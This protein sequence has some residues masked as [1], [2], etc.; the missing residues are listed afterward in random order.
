MTNDDMDLV[1]EYI[2]LHSEQ[3]FATLVHRHVNLV[4]SAAIRQVRDPLL[5]EEVTQ[6][7]FIILARK[8]GTLG[9]DTILPS[10]LYRTARFAAADALKLQHRRARR[11]QE[12]WMQPISNESESEVWEQIAPSLDAAIAGLNEQDR[13]AIVLRYFQ[14]KNLQEIGAA[15]GASED[16]AK[17]RV[18]RA[19]EKLRRFLAKRGITSRAAVI[20]AAISANSVQA[21][22]VSLAGSVTA[23]AFAKGATASGSTLSLMKGALKFMAWTKAKTITVAAVVAIFAVGTTTF[24]VR[25]PDP[26]RARVEQILEQKMMPGGNQW[27]AGMD[28]LWA[29]GT[30][31][32]PHLAAEAVRPDSFLSRTYPALLNKLPA[33]LRNRLPQPIDRAQLRQ[34]AMN[35]ISEFGPLAVRRAAPAVIAGLSE[36]DDRHNNYAVRCLRW[37]LPDS[38]SAVAILE[39]GLAGTKTNWSVPESFLSVDDSVWDK[40]PEV[41]PSLINQLGDAGVAYHYAIVLGRVGSNGAPAIPALIQVSDM[42]AAGF[43]DAESARW[44][45]VEGYSSIGLHTV[46]ARQD[47]KGI[48]HARAMAVLALGRIGIATPEVCA[49]VARA[50][51]APDAW[52]RQNA[53]KAVALLGPPMANELPELRSGLMDQDNGALAEKLLAIRKIGPDA[54]GALE[55]LRELAKPNKLRS[56]VVDP[57]S[58]VVGWGIEELSASAKMDIFGID[59]EE[60]RSYL[61]DIANQLGHW[62]WWA[63]A[64]FLAQLRAFS[65]DAVR[66]VEPLLDQPGN[67]PSSLAA[68]VILCHDKMHS[69]ALAVLRRNEAEGVLTERLQA[70]RWLFE[71]RGDINGLC[72]LIEEA[73]RDQ[74]ASAGQMAA[75]IA[76]RMGEAALPALPAF[77][78]A[79][80]HKDVF[81]RHW[82]GRLVLKLAP[83]E[84][85][86]QASK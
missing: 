48:N 5:A 11:E 66:D 42:G 9:S 17:K 82:A 69:K 61:Q 76:D 58:G 36:T 26:L 10:W 84:L 70:G 51:N 25:R 62:W 20:A 75:Q 28:E 56:L 33:N 77:K 35:V 73:F 14:N 60:G 13:H 1:R 46:K 85:P 80:W 55:T 83:E 22:P 43:P 45:L 59:P 38:A 67:E 78:A 19:L 32:V 3:A 41:V 52:V 47:D 6:A 44:H 39:Q 53:A 63:P 4:Y 81:V 64:E 54:R 7:V 40:I 18:H 79:L 86:I 57:R 31:I 8:A 21:A 27:Q 50:W 34:T 23:V 37:L 16:A 71:I 68:Y 65:T 12:A 2:A 74:Q 29:M 30:N 72:S 15:L 24:S 49:A